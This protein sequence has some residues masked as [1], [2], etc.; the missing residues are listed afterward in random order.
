MPP[1]QRR[2]V[3]AT[4]ARSDLWS[5]AATTY[6]MITGKSPKVIRLDQLPGNLAP[7]IGKMLEDNPDERYATAEEFKDQLRKGLATAAATVAADLA[8]GICPA[9]NA[10]NDAS[11]KF[12]RGC[13][14]SLELECLACSKGMPV[15]E[16][17]CGQC[18]TSQQEERDQIRTKLSD[19][20]EA[21]LTLAREHEYEHSLAQLSSIQE[22][23]HPF[24]E[25]IRQE[26]AKRIEAVTTRRDEQ[27]QLRDQL[28][29]LANQHQHN[30]NYA[31]EV[32][33]LEKIPAPLRTGNKIAQ[34]L[35]N[36]QAAR[37]ERVSL[38]AEIRDDVKKKQVDGLL[39]KTGRFLEL[40]P[41]NKKIHKLQKQLL[42]RQ[43][44]DIAVALKANDWKKVL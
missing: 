42:Q 30:H 9:C 6:Q 14:E 7:V 23:Q 27:Y 1:E 32:Q 43:Q 40:E 34:Q 16:N 18:G 41:G 25:D 12:C 29:E 36:A 22:D 19:T 39:E 8:A 33:E 35:S 10:A 13:G 26:A 24:T 28:V 5:L 17:F 37:D 4:D 15:W 31:A 11:R 3:T 38:E 44:K 20:L 21:S 2:D